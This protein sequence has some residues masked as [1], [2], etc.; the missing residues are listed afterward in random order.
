M[1][2]TVTYVHN[3][4]TVI[5]RTLLLAKFEDIANLTAEDVATTASQRKMFRSES[6]VMSSATRLH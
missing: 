1:T 6:S 4:S 2:M 3:S 5:C